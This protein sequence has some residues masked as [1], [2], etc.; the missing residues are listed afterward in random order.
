MVDRQW[1]DRLQTELRRRNLPAA[2]S[3]RLIEELADH[4]TDI[5]ME[6]KSMDAQ[7]STDD[8]IGAPEVLAAA[9]E[10]GFFT[11]SFA[12]RHP[13]LAF[14][15]CPVPAALLT[16]IAIIFVVVLPCEWIVSVSKAKSAA[17]MGSHSATGFEWAVAY[18]N[19]YVLRFVPFGLTAFLFARMARRAKQPA[20]GLAACACVAVFAYLFRAIIEPPTDRYALMLRVGL[21]YE[22]GL[23]QWGNGL[24]QMA[25][26]LLL[27]LWTW[28]RQAS[29]PRRECVPMIG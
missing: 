12:G 23:R 16:L 19:L 10:R 4:F 18:L 5:Q 9:A 14:V 13:L 20:W 11:R 3:A 2:Y 27:G 1:L 26:P 7:I 24:M 21:G 8:L 22:H 15:I 29:L 25:V 6:E 28:R 17:A